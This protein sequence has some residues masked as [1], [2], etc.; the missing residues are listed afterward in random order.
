MTEKTQ[1]VG[2]NFRFPLTIKEGMVFLNE[3][4]I[5]DQIAKEKVEAGIPASAKIFKKYTAYRKATNYLY[6]SC[7]YC[8]AKI[9]CQVMREDAKVLVTR[10]E[11]AHFHKTTTFESPLEEEIYKVYQLCKETGQ[12]N[13]KEIIMRDFIINSQVCGKLLKRFK[14]F[15][16][17][18]FDSL[19]TWLKEHQ[20]AY[21]LEWEEEPRDMYPRII[22]TASARMLA[23]YARYGDLLTFDVVHGVVRNTAHDCK[24]YRLGVFGVSDTNEELLLAGLAFMVDETTSAIFAVLDHFFQIHGKAPSSIMT[25]TQ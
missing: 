25:D 22:V 23:N 7:H 12:Q 16:H 2:S 10:V 1:Q 3:E 9:A 13:I 19:E 17:N 15:E 18:N 21:R 20:Y 4:E 11:N 14:E 8:S 24:K 5:Q 6:F